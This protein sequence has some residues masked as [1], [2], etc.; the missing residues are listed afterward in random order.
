MKV[1]EI[2]YSIQGEGSLTGMPSIFIR[3]AGCPLRC[4]WCDTKYAWSEDVGTE[5][6][7]DDIVDAVGKFQCRYVVVTGGEPMV[8]AELSELL[9]KLKAHDKHITIETAGIAFIP[10][11]M[12]DL[13]SISPKLSNAEPDDIKLAEIHN[14]SKPDIAILGELID[15]YNYQLKFVV[16]TQADLAEIENVLKMLGNFDPEKVMLMPQAS[17]REELITKSPMV[18]Q[19]CK[20]NGYAF[21]HRLQIML[22]DGKRGV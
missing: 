21:C 6:S 11:L 5:Y 19:L 4:K 8:N 22:W 14:Y 15:N 3:L 12:C 13:V 1:N 10:D 17:T 16:D 18:A 20:D 7:P 2:F 9:T